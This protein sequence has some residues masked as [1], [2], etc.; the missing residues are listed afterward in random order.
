MLRVDRTLRIA[1]NA[2]LARL[3]ARAV[4]IVPRASARRL[5]PSPRRWPT[6]VI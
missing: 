6:G 2:D 3:Q 1:V 4:D 5:T